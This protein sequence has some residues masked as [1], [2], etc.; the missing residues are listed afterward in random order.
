MTR[1][2]DLTEAR[3]SV[4]AH[5]R[6][7]LL[8]E[9]ED[10][11]VTTLR[12]LTEVGQIDDLEVT[13]WPATV[14]QSRNTIQRQTFEHYHEF[15][16]WARANGVTLVG[17]ET[18]E[19]TSVLAD[20]PQIVLQTPMIGLTIHVDGELAGI[21]PH[22]DGDEQ[23]TVADAIAALRTN[24]LLRDE[25]STDGVQSVQETCPTCGGDVVSILGLQSCRDCQWTGAEEML[26][27]D[28]PATGVL[29]PAQ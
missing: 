5:V 6:P 27:A 23:Y 2:I 15:T 1:H 28:G 21:F 17:F 9:P 11:K 20:E 22:R 4:T 26:A 13:A 18:T 3:V 10:T 14:R 8:F 16:T 25:P 24:S 12:T 29:K 7:T 19:T